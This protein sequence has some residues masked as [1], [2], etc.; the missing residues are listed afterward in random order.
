MCGKEF[1]AEGT[2]P[3]FQLRQT[4]REACNSADYQ[5]MVEAEPAIRQLL[6]IDFEKKVK[7]TVLRNFRTVINLTI[8]DNLQVGAKHQSQTIF[9]QYETARA[10]LAKTLEQEAEEKLEHNHQLQEQIKQKIDAY[11]NSVIA[12]NDCLVAMGL[13]R[14][15]LPA[16]KDTDLDPVFNYQQSAFTEPSYNIEDEQETSSEIFDAEFTPTEKNPVMSE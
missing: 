15:K 1:Y 6:K 5:G 8:N 11:N 12:I 10:N 4:L 14:G 3:H 13:G 7:R 16:I 2:V 9:S